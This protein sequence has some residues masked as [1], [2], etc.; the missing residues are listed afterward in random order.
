MNSIP[1]STAID[2]FKL[3]LDARRLSR[4]TVSDYDVTLRKFVA[5]LVDHGLPD[6]PLDS[7]T[8]AHVAGFLAAQTV[9]K[10]T[11]LNYHTGLSALWTWA[12][13]FEYARLNVVRQV[14]P[15][16]PEKRE[17]VPFTE[18]D[19]RRILDALVYTRPYARPG[20]RSSRHRLPDAERNRA[21]ILLLVDTGLRAA[22]LCQLRIRQVDL[23]NRYVLPFGKGDKERLI[24]FS[25]RTGQAL[26]KYLAPRKD[27]TI[28]AP[29]FAT[30]TGHAM[31][32][33]QLLKL[34]KTAGA[35]AD[36][37][38]CH[39]HRF[40]HT[41]AISYL[42]NGGDAYT[43]QRILGH[44]TMDMVKTYLAIAQV[45]LDRG[46]RLASPVEHWRL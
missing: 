7:L 30:S 1:L 41:F 23:R 24:P 33:T 31:D 12:V 32:R 37:P 19:L 2:G 18:D 5:Y 20:K 17:I 26:F 42:R 22:E 28:D 13:R 6:P 4:H 11:I 14:V 29:L 34:L 46:H 44:T 9:S 15:P 45:D 16:K 10:K 25:P 39:P 21:I 3:H 36:V 43:L 38:D 27:E 40:R 8:H 35:R